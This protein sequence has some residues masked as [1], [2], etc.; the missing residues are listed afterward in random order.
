MRWERGTRL[1]LFD[2]Y[3]LYRSD[4]SR[5]GKW[6][7]GGVWRKHVVFCLQFCSFIRS[8]VLPICVMFLF[9]VYL[10][11]ASAMTF[12]IFIFHVIVF[13]TVEEK[14]REG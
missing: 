4:S 8:F 11:Q 10:F 3:G 12:V 5:H 6:I 9:I 14:R 13:L 7:E 2:D 1:S